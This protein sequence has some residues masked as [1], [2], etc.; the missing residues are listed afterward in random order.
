[1][2]GTAH[3]VIFAVCWQLFDK[4]MLQASAAPAA[5]VKPAGVDRAP[6]EAHVSAP[7]GR[8]RA[9]P[10]PGAELEKLLKH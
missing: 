5:A 8:K 2:L 1:M 10:E 6:Q 9:L 3:S 4:L 7:G